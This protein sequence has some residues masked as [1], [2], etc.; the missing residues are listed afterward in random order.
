MKRCTKCKEIKPKAEYRKDKSRSDGLMSWC[1]T[2]RNK[3]QADRKKLR[4]RN[5]PGYREATRKRLDGLPKNNKGASSKLRFAVF[6]GKIIKGPCVICDDKNSHGHHDDYSKPLEVIWL[7]HS[8][9][10]QLH[11]GTLSPREGL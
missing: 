8:H 7:C 3:N 5:D 6:H 2:C 11:A 1:K 10:M 9:H 4:Y